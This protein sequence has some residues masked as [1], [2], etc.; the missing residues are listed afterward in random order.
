MATRRAGR[1]T[2]SWTEIGKLARAAAQEIGRTIQKPHLLTEYLTKLDRLTVYAKGRGSIPFWQRLSDKARGRDI[3]EHELIMLWKKP[4]ELSFAERERR[5]EDATANVFNKRPDLKNSPEDLHRHLFALAEFYDCPKQA[6]ERYR[7]H[8][9]DMWFKDAV[10]VGRYL[11]AQSRG[12][13]AWSLIQE[14]LP[15]W[16][17]VDPAQV[18]PVVFLVD[19]DLQRIMNAERCAEV[20]RTPRSEIDP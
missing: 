13:E 5:L 12:D 14:K 6:L 4:E 7:A 9:P 1:E 20:L 18:A 19:R 15:G 10:Y 3:P 16:V 17:A 11:A 2:G 8:Q